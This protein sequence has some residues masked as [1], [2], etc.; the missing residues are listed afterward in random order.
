MSD[1]WKVTLALLIWAPTYPW[2][3]YAGRREEEGGG[4]Q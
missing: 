4:K 1:F 3:A 2:L